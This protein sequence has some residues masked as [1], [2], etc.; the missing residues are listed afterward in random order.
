MPRETT[1]GYA[2]VKGVDVYWVSPGEGDATDR[3]ARRIR[4]LAVRWRFRPTMQR[5]G[6]SD[7]RDFIGPN[8]P[9]E[10]LAVGRSPW[11]QGGLLPLAR[12]RR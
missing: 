4:L 7:A 10:A 2:P 3:R 5:E 11:G 8:D 9:K 12:V 1:T 6:D